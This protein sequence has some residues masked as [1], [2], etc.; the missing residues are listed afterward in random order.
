MK[1]LYISALSIALM[2]FAGCKKDNIKQIYNP[3]T[4]ARIKFIHAVPGLPAIDGYVNNTKITPLITSSVT[5]NSKTTSIISGILFLGTANANQYSGIFPSNTDYAVVTPGN[6]NITIKTATPVPALVSPQTVAPG[7]TIVNATQQMD[8]GKYYSVFAEGLPDAPGGLIIEDKFTQPAA[9]NKVY[10]RFA[11]MIPNSPTNLDL[12]VSYTL[13]GA[14]AAATPTV[15]TNIGFKTVTD[16]VALDANSVSTTGYVFSLYKTGTQTKVGTSSSSLVFTPG[17]YY[18]ILAKGLGADYPLP[19][20]TI[21]LKAS[22]RPSD[23]VNNKIP[24]IY[25][26]PPNITFIVNR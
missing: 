19:G 9:S 26:N 1:K 23:N 21:T 5:D 17:R 25:F 2:A 24:E 8:D 10:V 7:A 3:A 15:A 14:T 12:G 16:W 6:N 11:N 22:A 18:T 13:T 20:T 4:G